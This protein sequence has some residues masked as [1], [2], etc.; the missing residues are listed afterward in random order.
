MKVLIPTG[1]FPPEIGGPATYVPLIARALVNRGHEVTVITL[2]EAEGHDDKQYPFRVIRLLPYGRIRRWMHTVSQLIVLMRQ[3]DMVYVNGL[4]LETYVASLTNRKPMV[5]KVVGDIAWERAR[6]KGWVTESNDLFQQRVYD[7]RI[8]TRRTMRD[9]ALGRMRQ[10]IVPSQY[11]KQIV[12]AWNID[13][14]LIDVIYNA[15]RPTPTEPFHNPLT[16]HTKLVTV[17]RLVNWK[18]VDKII[19][20]LPELPDT[21]LLVVGEGPERAGLEALVKKHHLS[22]R[23]HFTGT[24]EHGQ[25]LSAIRS[26]DLFV[27]NS[28]YEGL[29][30]VLLEALAMETPIVATRVGGTP[31]LVI[32]GKNGRLVPFGHAEQLQMAISEVAA[33]PERYRATLPEQF[34]PEIMVSQ[35]IDLLLEVGT[36]G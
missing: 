6:A 7:R 31:E 15:Y 19:S 32:D 12:S 23:V 2:T 30:H 11:L 10:I 26:S 36:A 29:P 9:L 5:A 28:S 14:R 3:H 17:C 13:G 34:Q 21:G 24:V 16:T 22:E 20:L 4:L 18:G 27:L 25:V 1:A 33:H 8:E 35:T